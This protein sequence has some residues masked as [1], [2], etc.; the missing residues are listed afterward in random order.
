MAK[1][2]HCYR[3]YPNLCHYGIS[4]GFIKS[5]NFQILLEPFE[6]KFDLPAIFVEVSKCLGGKIEVV[7]KKKIGELPTS[8]L[9]LGGAKVDGL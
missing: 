9:S 4:T 3:G 1:H 6:G 8:A 7:G 5:F 2:K